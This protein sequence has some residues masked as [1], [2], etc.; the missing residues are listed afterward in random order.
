MHAAQRTNVDDASLAFMQVRICRLGHEERA[1]GVGL[2]HVV[3]LGHGDR[4]Q[5]R[6]LKDSSVI[7]QDI[8]PAELLDHARNRRGDTFLIAHV[9]L[10]GHRPHLVLAQGFHRGLR[11]RRGTAVGDGNIRPGRCQAEC[12]ASANAFGGSRH[13]RCFWM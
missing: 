13:Q 2:E 4:L 3:P 1:A 5:H 8:Q 10:N 11:F 12:K 9:A 6:G 7:D